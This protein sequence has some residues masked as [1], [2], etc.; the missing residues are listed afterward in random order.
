[1]MKDIDID[2]ANYAAREELRTLLLSL[3]A[4]QEQLQQAHKIVNTIETCAKNEIH[5]YITKAVADRAP[6]SL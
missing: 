6:R 3:G 2:N 1:M 5:N 4:T